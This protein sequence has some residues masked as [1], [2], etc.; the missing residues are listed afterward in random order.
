MRTSVAECIARGQHTWILDGRGPAQWAGVVQQD[1]ASRLAARRCIVAQLGGKLRVPPCGQRPVHY[2]VRM[3]LQHTRRRDA[4]GILL[5]GLA[6]A[7][8][9]RVARAVPPLEELEEENGR[10]QCVLERLENDRY[11]LTHEQHR[12]EQRE[13]GEGRQWSG[14]WSGD[15]RLLVALHPADFDPHELEPWTPMW[16]P[17]E[18]VRNVVPQDPELVGHLC[19]RV[20]LAKRVLELAL[21]L[22]EPRLIRGLQKCWVRRAG[23]TTAISKQVVFVPTN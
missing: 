4:L 10:G 9:P 13:L 14:S 23:C 5:L 18:Q 2:T 11:R 17:A 12:E 19:V 16:R 15:E 7:S 21:A 22:L 6:P 20:S 1:A 3:R 8:P